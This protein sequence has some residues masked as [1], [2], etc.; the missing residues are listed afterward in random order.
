MKKRFFPSACV[1]V[2]QNLFGYHIEVYQQGQLVESYFKFSFQAAKQM[3]SEVCK[4]F[5]KS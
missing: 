2:R 4:R 1:L 3:F 5:Q